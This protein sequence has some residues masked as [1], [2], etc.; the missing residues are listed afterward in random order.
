MSLAL[1][2]VSEGSTAFV[3]ASLL[4]TQ[5]MLAFQAFA[6]VLSDHAVAEQALR[7]SSSSPSLGSTVAV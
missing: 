1:D 2:L 7:A 6:L 5:S 4:I 3:V